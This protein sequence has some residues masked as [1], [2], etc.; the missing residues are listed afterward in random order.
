M[1]G[2]ESRSHV[3]DTGID[4]EE[5]EEAPEIVVK[6]P[7]TRAL[8]NWPRAISKT[9]RLYCTNGRYTRFNDL[10]LCVPTF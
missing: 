2:F 3:L 1:E 7:T 5:D 10:F 8:C 9:P 6:I 4:R